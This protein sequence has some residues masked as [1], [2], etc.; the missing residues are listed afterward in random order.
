MGLRGTASSRF[1]ISIMIESIAEDKVYLYELEPLD[2]QNPAGGVYE[3][4]HCTVCPYAYSMQ[5][6]EAQARRYFHGRLDK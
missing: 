4:E 2:D 1:G 5:P 6:Q 3:F